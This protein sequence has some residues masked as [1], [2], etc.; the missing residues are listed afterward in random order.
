MAQRVTTAEGHDGDILD[1][2]E[3]IRDYSRMMQ[4]YARAGDWDRLLDLQAAYVGAMEALANAEREVALSADGNDRKIDL[5][6]EIR[7]AEAE[8]REC[9]DRRMSE[10]SR[11]MADSRQRWNAARAYE[12]QGR[13]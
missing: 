8:V 1:R 11:D 12:T 2:Y 6:G 3:K 10:L 4:H 9:L 13:A 5:I 7:I